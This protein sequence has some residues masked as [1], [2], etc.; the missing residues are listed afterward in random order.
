M[1]SVCARRKGYLATPPL[2]YYIKK[3]CCV[4]NAAGTVLDKI[5][6]LRSK[7]YLTTPCHNGTQSS[8]VSL[9]RSCSWSTCLKLRGS[10]YQV[11]FATVFFSCCY[12]SAP[13]CRFAACGASADSRQYFFWCGWGRFLVS[14]W[15]SGHSPTSSHN[16]ACCV[17]NGPRVTSAVWASGP[18]GALAPRR[19]SF[20]PVFL[21]VVA[22]CSL[23]LLLLWPL[24]DI[25]TISP[26]DLFP[27][28]LGCSRSFGCP[29]FSSFLHSFS[30]YSVSPVWRGLPFRPAIVFFCLPLRAALRSAG[31][32]R[33]P[34]LPQ[35]RGLFLG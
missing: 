19:S 8:F 24:P 17:P 18:A 12:G 16:T 21:L 11:F 29:T 27:T 31:W 2:P 22:Y 4:P 25:S 34:F 6:N 10:P 30:R 32:L 7:D 35:H 9:V 14:S 33:L 28:A 15:L 26:G 20:P 23:L 5:A 13:F 1:S 3:Q